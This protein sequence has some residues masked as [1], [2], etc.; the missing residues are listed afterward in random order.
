[1][2]IQNLGPKS[3]SGI[4]AVSGY[5]IPTM[6][7]EFHTW[8]SFVWPP[9]AALRRAVNPLSLA[10]FTSAFRRTHGENA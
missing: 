7:S 8:Y 5:N 1:M 10:A 6:Q 2:V 9:S 4:A 3:G